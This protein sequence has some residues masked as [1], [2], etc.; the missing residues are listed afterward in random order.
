IDGVYYPYQTGNLPFNNVA[1]VEVDKGP[2]GTLFG[3]NAT[4]GVIQITTRDPQNTPAGNIEIGYGNYNTTTANAYVTT[5]ITDK[6][7]AD[8]AIYYLD[9]KD[10]WG[11]NLATG[12]DIFT[13]KNLA[14]RSKWLYRV[15]DDTSVRFTWDYLT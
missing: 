5:G 14:L 3:R 15:S 11:R 6:L 12:S 8:L 4:G 9:Q 1:S 7:A 10:G 13:E 2:Q